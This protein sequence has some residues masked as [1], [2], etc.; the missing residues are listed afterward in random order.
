MMGMGEP[1]HNLKEVLEAV[2]FLGDVLGLA[3][4]EIVVANGGDPEAF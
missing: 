3:H 4:K 1:S 2:N